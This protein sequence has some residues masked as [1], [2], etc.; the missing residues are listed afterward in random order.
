MSHT[1]NYITRLPT[2]QLVWQ[3]FKIFISLTFVS[4]YDIMEYI[5]D[6]EFTVIEI[7]NICLKHGLFLAP[8]AG[9]TDKTF[10]ALCRAHGAEFTVS[11]MISAKA[12]CYE[13]L[14]KKESIISKT[15]PLAFLDDGEVPAAVQ[16]FGRDPEFMAQ[17]ARMLESGEYRGRKGN[18][19][20]SAIDI[21]MGCPVHKVESNGEGSALM[22]EP[23]LAC[24]IVR[25]V[26]SALVHTPVTVKIR[27]GFSNSD[28]NAPEMA[29]MLEDAGASLICIH[30]RTREQMYNPGIDMSVIEKVKRAVS[31]P[32]VGNGDIYSGSDALDMMNKTGCDGVAVGRGARGNPWIFEDIAACLEGREYTYPDFCDRIDTISAQLSDM[33]KEKGEVI[34]AAEAKKHIAWY[35]RD[36]RDGTTLRDRVMKCENVKELFRM[37]EELRGAQMQ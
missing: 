36:V 12:L 22:K 16:I 25:A 37:I 18:T 28:K 4:F 11:E 13:Q 6:L 30:A 27:A 26:K 5:K 35:I 19:L 1:V 31:I 14:A 29:K 23:R 33:V 3:F 17:A 21:N 15:G 34:A 32:V 24:D 20:P 8:M 9:V 7:G 10:R 2:C